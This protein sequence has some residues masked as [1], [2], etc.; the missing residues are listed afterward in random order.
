MHFGLTDEQRLIVETTRAFV[1]AELYPHEAEIERLV[2]DL[3]IGLHHL[4][5]QQQRV[6][7]VLESLLRNSV[8]GKHIGQ[9][10]FDP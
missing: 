10:V 9:A 8:G 5:R 2:G 6:L 4:R 3:E 1:E 7:I